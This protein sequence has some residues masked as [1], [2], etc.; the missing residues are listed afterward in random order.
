VN[1][2]NKRQLH[3]NTTN[4]IKS[5]LKNKISADTTIIIG[6]SIKKIILVR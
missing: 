3:A 5:E 1:T 2:L 4:K 6:K